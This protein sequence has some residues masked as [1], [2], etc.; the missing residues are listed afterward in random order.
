M[1]TEVSHK[2]HMHTE[3]LHVSQIYRQIPICIIYTQT[4]TGR[5]QV[6]HPPLYSQVLGQAFLSHPARLLP[7]SL[8]DLLSPSSSSPPPS[9]SL[10]CIVFVL[11]IGLPL[12]SA[13]LLKDPIL[14][15]C[16]ESPVPWS[17]APAVTWR[18]HLSVSLPV[19]GHNDVPPLRRRQSPWRPQISSLRCW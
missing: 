8:Q 19:K 16:I 5:S 15:S 14:M 12:L 7:H 11:A 13:S 4:C 1:Y 18:S 17:S 3:I 9:S 10:S 2:S 6:A